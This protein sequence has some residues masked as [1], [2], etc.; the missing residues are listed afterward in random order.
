[1]D[2]KPA[3][4]SSSDQENKNVKKE[5]IQISTDNTKQILYSK[6]TNNNNNNNN[7]YKLDAIQFKNSVQFIK[8]K[9]QA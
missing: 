3:L 4:T 9:S 2:L 7:I 6:H 8:D 5:I 1:M